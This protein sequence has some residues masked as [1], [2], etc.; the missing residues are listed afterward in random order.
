MNTQEALEKLLRAYGDYYDVNR[1]D[2]TPPFAAEAVFHSHDER[3]FLIKSAKLSESESHEYVFFAVEETLT[4][5]RLKELVDIAWNTGTGR[6][7]P[8]ESHQCSD[9]LVEILADSISPE[10]MK[11][12][13]KLRRYKSYRYTLHGWSHFR[14]FAMEVSSGKLVFNRQGRRLKKIFQSIGS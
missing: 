10:A 13:P 14:L 12:I 1:E 2:P 5:E 11:L 8:Y 6:V 9:V 7:E 4:A 3:F